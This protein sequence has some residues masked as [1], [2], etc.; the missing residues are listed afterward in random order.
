[1]LLPFGAASDVTERKATEQP[2]REREEALSDADRRKDECLAMLAHELRNPLA[3]I[4][5]ASELLSRTL[6]DTRAQHAV[7]VIK[8]QGVH[9]TRLVDGG[10]RARARQGST[11]ISSS[12]STWFGLS[13]R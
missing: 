9:L 3:P 13:G 1:V 10:F 12:R 6:D 5:T 7:D 2:L 11:I 8:R 4:A